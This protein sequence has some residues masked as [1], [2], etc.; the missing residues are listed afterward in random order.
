MLVSNQASLYFFPGCTLKGVEGD[1][2]PEHML[3]YIHVGL[4]SDVV[5]EWSGCNIRD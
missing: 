4:M 5:I 1:D 2:R 3:S